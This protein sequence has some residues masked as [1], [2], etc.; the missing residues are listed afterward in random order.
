MCTNGA[1]TRGMTTI[2]TRPA[3]FLLGLTHPNRVE[4]VTRGSAAYVIASACSL[5]AISPASQLWRGPQSDD[6]DNEGDDQQQSQAVAGHSTITMD[7]GWLRARSQMI[8]AFEFP[9]Y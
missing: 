7:C 1:K 2:S 9:L 4:H 3:T 5:L 8:V 6:A